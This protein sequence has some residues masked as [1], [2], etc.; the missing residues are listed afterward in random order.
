MLKTSQLVTSV[1]DALSNMN[2]DAEVLV[3]VNYLLIKGNCFFVTCYIYNN[4]FFDFVNLINLHFTFCETLIYI[5]RYGNQSS[6]FWILLIYVI[7]QL[8]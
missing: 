3:E 2:I 1:L 8:L 7:Y 5:F 4:N 6:K